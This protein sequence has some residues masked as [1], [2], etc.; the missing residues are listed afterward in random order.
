MDIV[1]YIRKPFTVRAVE[2]T[3][4]N[5]EQVAEWCKGTV[6]EQVSK[7]MGSEIKLPVI[8]IQGQGDNRGKEFTAALGCYVV[9]LKGAFRVYKQAQ[10]FQSFETKVVYRE[11]DDIDENDLGAHKDYDEPAEP[12]VAQSF[13]PVS[14]GQI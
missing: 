2:V 10:F 1:E 7:M 8:K 14:P 9:E 5:I 3:F 12:F 4:K 6:E 11:D 13:I